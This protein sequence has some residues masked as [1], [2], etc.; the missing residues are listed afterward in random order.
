MEK[1]DHVKLDD[2]GLVP[3]IV[4]HAETGEVRMLG[5]ADTEALHAT[6]TRGEVYFHSRS[7]DALWKKGETSG[8]VLHVVD[9]H[10]DCDGDAVLV[11]ALP[12]GPTC[13]TGADSCFH[14]PMETENSVAAPGAGDPLRDLESIIR[15]RKAS[16]KAGSYTN[17]LL[18]GGVEAI[19]AKVTEEAEEVVRAA[20]SEGRQR[21]IE[22]AADVLY[23]LSVLMAASDVTVSDVAA[24]LAARRR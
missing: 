24:E 7:R 3:V 17:A 23:H 20:R 4:Q 19:G 1:L 10:L 16:P 14:R 12:D 5:Y 21:V 9:V 18:D 11:R 2:A 15:A 8:N 22:E 6:L 13:H